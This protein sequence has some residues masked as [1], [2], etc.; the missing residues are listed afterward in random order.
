MATT[1]LEA[2]L[3]DAQRVG[4]V[5]AGPVRAHVDHARAF[6]EL[7][8]DPP[9]G[10]LVDLGSGAGLPGLVLAM[11][12]P[13]S[14]WVLLDGRV[15]SAEFLAEAVERL[16][17]ADR[18][19]V[20]GGRA[21]VIAHDPVYRGAADVV[22]ARSVAPP[23]AVAECAAGFLVAGGLLAVSEPPDGGVVRWDTAGLAH[24]GMGPVRSIE[25]SGRLHF[26]LVRQEAPC[27]RGYPRRTGVP[28]RRPLF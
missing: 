20:V 22:V 16:R 12:W 24:L 4:L 3:R 23:G 28:V 9:E 26:S 21:E 25:T 18:V 14:L 13:Q 6:A 1:D 19:T 10:L 2:L 8:G 11:E 5:G 15:R 17:L 27:P 7:F